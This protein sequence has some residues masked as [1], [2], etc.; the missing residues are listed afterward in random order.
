MGEVGRI[1]F[2]RNILQS[3]LGYLSVCSLLFDIEKFILTKGQRKNNYK[4]HPFWLN[5]QNLWIILSDN[6]D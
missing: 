6:L 3:T 5:P 4:S 2:L 1:S